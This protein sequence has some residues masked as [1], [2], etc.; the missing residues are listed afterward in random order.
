[1]RPILGSDRQYSDA[2]RVKNGLKQGQ[3]LSPLP[4][5]FALEYAI[6]NVLENQ[7]GVEFIWNA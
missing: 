5:K 6:K 1:M 7:D 3:T 2:F 4:L